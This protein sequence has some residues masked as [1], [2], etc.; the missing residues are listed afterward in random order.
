MDAPTATRPKNFSFQ[1]SCISKKNGGHLTAV[2]VL[3]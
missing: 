1:K 2:I 3:F